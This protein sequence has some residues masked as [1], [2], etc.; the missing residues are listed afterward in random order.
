M[1][2]GCGKHQKLPSVCRGVLSARKAS[3]NKLKSDVKNIFNISG[4]LDFWTNKD[5]GPLWTLKIL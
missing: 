2:T 4:F 5:P 1:G 3:F